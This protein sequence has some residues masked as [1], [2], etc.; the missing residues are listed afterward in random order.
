MPEPSP[1]QPESW[2]ESLQHWHERGKQRVSDARA[3]VAKHRADQ[4]W[5]P[6]RAA[7]AP[8]QPSA[9]AADHAWLQAALA[10][11]PSWPP[12]PYGVSAGFGLAALAA[13]RS[14]STA[15]DVQPASA[16]GTRTPSAEGSTGLAAAIPKLESIRAAI[17]I[18]GDV[19]QLGWTQ[20]AVLGGRL[21][22]LSLAPLWLGA[23]L[24]LPATPGKLNPVS[25]MTG[26]LQAAAA[27]L[28]TGVTLPLLCYGFALYP[29]E[30]ALRK[31]LASDE[32]VP[33]PNPAGPQSTPPLS[34]VEAWQELMLPS[35]GLG[36]GTR[37]EPSSA[38]HTRRSAAN[39][40]DM[41]A[42]AAALKQRAEH[43]AAGHYSALMPRRLARPW[44][45]EF[46]LHP[47]L[48]AQAW[49][50]V[51][52]TSVPVSA[53]V[54][55]LAASV[56]QAP[57]EA[58]CAALSFSPT[59][60]DVSLPAHAVAASQLVQSHTQLQPVG[61]LYTTLRR[62]EAPSS[63][64]ATGSTQ[65]SEEAGPTGTAASPGTMFGAGVAAGALAAPAA[66]HGHVGET[67]RRLAVK[68]PGRAP[69]TV[70][71]GLI[72][73]GVALLLPS[74]EDAAAQFGTTA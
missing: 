69:F 37:I 48:V 3:A 7:G 18:E 54:S 41:L 71:A 23:V 32:H 55:A 17:A 72:G 63:Q 73:G 33:A 27:W 4:G 12:L 61:R 38:T 15:N 22:F 66:W 47:M 70:V 20:R 10:D 57:L 34:A 67:W 59:L 35:A 46:S 2:W 64:A 74:F 1:S 28:V 62:V 21:A 16:T 26:R 9:A 24:F 29:V 49:S 36:L 52:G 68:Q 11:G 31:A 45:A 8:S 40:D 5:Q 56:R 13:R 19:S 25:A 6:T 39:V 60:G 58:R 65:A 50:S 53:R 43:G 44:T 30:H 42:R 51:P 14:D